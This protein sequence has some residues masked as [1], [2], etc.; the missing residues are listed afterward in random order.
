[1]AFNPCDGCPY[2]REYANI[3]AE[4]KDIAPPPY[5]TD[6][7]KS[8]PA[9]CFKAHQIAYKLL[10]NRYEELVEWIRRNKFN[11]PITMR[12]YTR[13]EYLERQRLD[14]TFWTGRDW[15]AYNEEQL[16][17]ITPWV[18]PKKGEKKE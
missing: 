8:D 3:P 17:H 10:E 18:F 1:M 4:Y 14:P 6:E 7:D 9:I 15:Q 5:C 12:K 11:Y 13:E 16:K 2:R